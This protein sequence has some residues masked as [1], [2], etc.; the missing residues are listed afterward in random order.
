VVV[1]A[2][3]ACSTPASEGRVP[4]GVRVLDEALDPARFLAQAA[5]TARQAGAGTLVPVAASI[6]SEGD[7]LGSFVEV[8]PSQC[9]LVLARPG[10]S[11]RDVDLFVYSDGGDLLASDEAPEAR[12]SALVCPP[13]PRRVYLAARVVS[14]SGV[15]AVGVMA[16]AR[17]RADAVAKSLGVRGRPG[18]DTG[19][20]EAWP[21]LER[22]IRERRRQLGSTWED[23]RRAAMPL[24]PRSY[25][26]LTVP[27]DAGRCLDVLVT[28]SDEVQGID[29]FVVDG[30]GRV[31]ARG[32]PPGRDRTFVLCSQEVRTVTI[33]V[34]PR[35]TGG[36]AAVIVG[37]SPPGAFEEVRE[38]SWVDGATP[39]VPLAEALT[40]HDQRL[41]ALGLEPAHDLGT[42][43]V[44]IGAVVGL[45]VKLK[46]GCTRIDAVGGRPLG[47]FSA[48]LWN[49]DGERLASAQ[50]GEY[51]ALFWCGPALS[52]RI[53]LGTG[54]RNGK[55][56]LRARQAKTAP[57]LLVDHPTAAARL[58]ER[59]EA[60]AGPIDP[61]RA[62]GAELV[63][64]DPAR[65]HALSLDVAAGGCVEIIAAAGGRA[66]GMELVLQEPDS[67]ASTATRGDRL[68]SGR[69]CSSDGVRL[70]AEVGVATGG[71]VL[72]LRRSFSANR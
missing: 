15:V 13:H 28:P 23:V 21:G 1:L 40:R 6:M 8:D 51:A 47:H 65:R 37:R 56:A 67:Q 62:A 22:K 45:P 66:S 24:D 11:V 34:R 68:V 57:K 39:L 27:I 61:S 5:R 10:G 14:G 38:H 72:L 64:L 29:A 36:V 4:G 9:V 7:Q 16:V 20:L 70:R 71:D 31:V 2:L 48:E 53:E 25:S 44:K 60:E 12:A 69:E 46:A 55:I 52:A 41:A 30:D 42:V 43:D 3:G 18:E 19:R 50:G 59:L 33:M 32:R 35:V 26:V 17:R 49:E 58:L 63:R 54:E